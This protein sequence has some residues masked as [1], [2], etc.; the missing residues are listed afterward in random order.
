MVLYLYS[1]KFRK[2]TNTYIK[3]YCGENIIHCVAIA[4]NNYLKLANQNFEMYVRLRVLLL[5]DKVRFEYLCYS[6]YSGTIDYRDNTDILVKQ[7]Y[8]PSYN[9]P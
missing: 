6:H 9:V 1:N 2:F 7:K 4:F 8:W 3:E 5:Q